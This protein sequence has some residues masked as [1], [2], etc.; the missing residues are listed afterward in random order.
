MRW[1][2]VTKIIMPW[3]V[4]LYMLLRLNV[5]LFS[6]EM[7]LGTTLHNHLIFAMLIFAMCKSLIFVS[8]EL[9][10]TVYV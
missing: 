8:T 7:S 6:L 9:W 5:H 2:Y 3:E 10:N 1:A 4:K